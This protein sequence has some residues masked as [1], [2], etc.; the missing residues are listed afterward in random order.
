LIDEHDVT[1]R[2]A[3]E[4]AETAAQRSAGEA[5]ETAAQRSAR[6]AAAAAA[7]VPPVPVRKRERRRVKA[8]AVL[9]VLVLTVLGLASYEFVAKAGHTQRAAAATHPGAQAPLAPA[10]TSAAA[11]TPATA[12]VTAGA[13]SASNAPAANAPASSAPA[14]TAPASTA[15]AS[16]A[17]ASTPP[18]RV[19]SVASVAAF[20]PDGTTD[21][22][23]PENVAQA[24]ADDPGNPWYTDW[25]ASPDF[26][27]MAPGTGLL[28]DLGR[29]V[30]VTS[31][32]VSL[33]GAPGASL[34]LRA[35]SEPTPAGLPAVA[36]VSGAGGTVQLR[37][38]APVHVRYVLIWFTRLPPTPAG[39]YQA[40]VYQVVV[41]G[42]P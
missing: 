19:L 36:G 21:G 11:V 38:S 39:T 42:Q 8:T 9:A 5:A 24:V 41:Q 35:G 33:G 32:S 1:Q 20:G 10:G 23:N 3:P 15:S 29:T 34:Q 14:S 26:F 28:L 16:T 22:N 25:Y 12:G 13:S 6:E 4:P 18:P 17:P 31:V 37:R 2:S 27:D 7:F 30:T 40:S